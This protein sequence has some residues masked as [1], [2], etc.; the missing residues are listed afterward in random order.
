MKILNFFSLFFPII[1]YG[2]LFGLNYALISIGFTLV[3]GVSKILNLSYGALYMTTAYMIYFFAV[4]NNLPLII[5]ILISIIITI[6][7]GLA[8]FYTIL[9]FTVNPMIFMVTMLLFALLLQYIYSYLFGG[10]VG[11][12]IPSLFPH[13]S[14]GLFGVSINLSL[15]ASS[16]ISLL[17]IF[18]VSF[19]IYKT[20]I[21]R[22]IRATAEDPEVSELLGINT[23]QIIIIVL[24]ISILLVSIA[25]IL[26]VPTEEVTPTMWVDPF[27]IA[28]AV[29]IIGGLGKFEWAIPAAF[30]V[31]FA[32]VISQYLIPYNVS[33]IVAF[34]IVILFIV[35]FPNGLGG[36]RIES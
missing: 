4:M 29:S 21:G 33:D 1:I 17:L 32:E 8:I 13:V 35:V 3:F 10:Q 20:S 15:L 11:L 27:V 24:S 2:L 26:L 36:A 6:L 34:I 28:F 18:L 7:I 5:S 22:R 23:K 12:I 25:S 31:S 30:I 14:I 19:W 16:L 9:K